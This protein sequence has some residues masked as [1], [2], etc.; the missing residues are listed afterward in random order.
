[1]SYMNF[2][3]MVPTENGNRKPVLEWDL[4]KILEI[5][6][7]QLDCGKDL[8]TAFNAAIEEFKKGTTKLPY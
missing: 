4:E 1:M 3:I 2:Y 6:Q 8:K 7:T 5:V